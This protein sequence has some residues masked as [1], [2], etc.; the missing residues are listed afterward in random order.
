MA[1]G[2]EKLDLPSVAERAA[3]QILPAVVHLRLE[4]SKEEQ[5]K[6]ISDRPEQRG[7]GSGVVIKED[8]TILTNFH[9]VAAAAQAKLM[10]SFADGSESE[11]L[12]IQV[13]PEKDLAIVRP[14]KI[15]DDI[16]AATIA[17]SGDLKPGD[18][19][20]AVGFPFGIGPSVSAGVVSGLDREFRSP[21][22]SRSLRGLIQF[23]AAANPGSSGGPLVN[24]H[25]EVVGI[26]TA[27]LNP[28]KSRTFIGIG[29]ATTMES[30]GSAM[31]LPRF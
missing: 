22:G 6:T 8:G 5:G 26:V 31:G 12:V 3:R 25:G 28:E 15:P 24:Q 10:I 17:G 1:Q 30:A 9:V 18:Q 16:Q 29:F 20:V 23:D 13:M 11:G 2:L 19:V 7:S 4:F 21:D 27:I 14:R